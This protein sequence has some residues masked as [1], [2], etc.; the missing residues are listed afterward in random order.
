M[1]NSRKDCQ[2]SADFRV[3]PDRGRR[4][5]VPD[6]SRQ[7][8]NEVAPKRN[9]AGGQAREVL[10]EAH[11]ARHALAKLLGKRDNDALGPADVG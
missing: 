11:A 2:G 7:I 3:E 4:I 9:L 10:D 8:P 6:D 5:E 1:K